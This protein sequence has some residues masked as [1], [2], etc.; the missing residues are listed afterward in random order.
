MPRDI[1]A[2]RTRRVL[3]TLKFKDRGKEVL[4]VQSRL[5]ALGYNVGTDGVDGFFGEDTRDAVVLFQQDNGLVS[6]G[7]VGE[8]TWCELVESMYEP[9]ERL[10]Y[11]RIPPFRGADVL[12]L[13]KAINCL[14]FNAGPEDG[15]FGRQTERAVLD[16]QKN[17]GLVVD[18]MIDESVL[19][20]V[21]KVTKDGEPHNTEAKIP[22]R[23]GG[24][25]SGRSL[26]DITIVIDPGH[27]GDD[28][29]A[30]SES[31]IKEKD[32]NLKLAFRLGKMLEAAGSKIVMTR[33]SDQNLSLYERPAAANMAQGDIFISIHHNNNE[34]PK[35]QG[36]V[37]YYF[38]RQGYYSEAGRALADHIVSS[39]SNKL[40]V[41]EIRAQG[42]NF[43]VLRETEMTGV[44]IEPAFITDPSIWEKMN[45]E[46]FIAREAEAIFSGLTDYFSP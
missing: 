16:F 2:K 24:Y 22:D 7:I 10:L 17:A 8:N 3:K 19:N 45:S 40:N 44:Q 9:G 34:S 35:A 4:D 5:R 37:A 30:V 23:N 20:V 14:G 18:G 6:D 13:Q 31:G 21:A 26:A 15:I 28:D 43:T 25:I 32:L 11:L 36:A 38:C 33:D 1:R 42:R 39:I 46:E 29:G 27:G 41:P 12:F